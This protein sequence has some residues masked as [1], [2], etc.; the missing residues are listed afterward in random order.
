M[1]LSIRKCSP[2][3]CVYTGWFLMDL[4]IRKFSHIVCVY[5]GWFLMNLY[6][7][8]CSPIIWVYTGLF[9]MNLYIRKFSP[10][11]CV[12]TGWFL[13][14]LYIHKFS[15]IIYR[16]ILNEPTYSKIFYYTH[17]YRVILNEP[18]I[19]EFS[20]IICVYTGWFLMNLIIIKSFNSLWSIGHIHEELPAIA[21]SIYPLDLVPWYSCASY[22]IL[23]CPS[24]HSL[25]PTSPSISLRIPI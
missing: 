18:H 5:T 9:L 14:N 25:R 6:I 17:I 8:K 7:R 23:C 10:I 19:Y 2:I 15:P 4:Y 1:N 22:V 13:M 11:I 20:P 24:P 3:I 16:M 21:V 12:Y